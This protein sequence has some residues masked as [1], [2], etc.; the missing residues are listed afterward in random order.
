MQIIEQISDFIK[1]K[2]DKNT[3]LIEEMSQDCYSPR[4]GTSRAAIERVIE[5]NGESI[6][7]KDIFKF[8]LEK[9]QAQS[10]KR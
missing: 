4:E 10:F 1:D 3:L 8:I 2:I 6:A 5:L 9:T 7:C